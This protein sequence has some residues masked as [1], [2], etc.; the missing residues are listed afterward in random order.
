MEGS[1]SVQINAQYAYNHNGIRTRSLS[2]QT[3]N[4]VTSTNNR[5]FLVDEQNHT[6]YAQVLEESATLGGTPVT[7]YTLGDDVI[8]QSSA[9]GVRHLLYD[10]HGSTRLL[11]SNSGTITDRYDFDAY[12]KTVG[13]DPNLS[14]PAATNMLYSGEQFDPELNN[15]YLR[16]RYF[17]QNVGRFTSLDKFAGNNSDP[18]SLHKYAYTHCDPISGIDPSGMSTL[19]ELMVAVSIS[20]VIEIAIALPGIIKDW[21]NLTIGDVAAKLGIAAGK[22]LVLGV[23]GGVGGKVALKLVSQFLPKLSRFFSSAF[24]GMAGAAIS[25]TAKEMFMVLFYGEP[26]DFKERAGRVIVA[27]CVGFAFGAFVFNLNIVKK[28][29]AHPTIQFQEGLGQLPLSWLT[30]ER[31]VINWSASGVWGSLGAEVVHNFFESELTDIMDLYL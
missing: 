1:G 15:Y 26:V 7:S 5:F 30:V 16:A 12:G 25:S 27:A 20:V 17:D 23:L 31:E 21:D 10:G 4:G 8:S 11:A 6:G 24:E 29:E 13:G 19:T 14:N 18:Q 2:T 22:G 9:A 28:V 3:I